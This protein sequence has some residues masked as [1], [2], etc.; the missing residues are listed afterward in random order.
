MVQHSPGKRNILVASSLRGTIFSKAGVWGVTSSIIAVSLH[1]ILDLEKDTE[2]GATGKMLGAGTVGASILGGFT[3]ILGFLIAFRSQQAYSRWWEGGAL[4]QQLRA[5]WFN[6]ASCLLAFS[7]PS[8]EK[9]EEVKQ[10]QNQLVRLI[11]LLHSFALMAVSTMKSKRF[12]L[13]D[14]RGFDKEAL[15]FLHSDACHDKCEVVLQWI[16]RAIVIAENRKVIK[17][18][19]PILSRVYSQLGNGIVNLSNA[20]KITE[21]QIPSPLAQM[22]TVM[23]L[24]HWVA[25]PLICATTVETPYWAGFLCFIVVFSY[26]T[27][28]YIATEL[29]M[30]FGNDLHDLPLGEMQADLNASLLTLLQETTLKCPGY[31]HDSGNRNNYTVAVDLGFDLSAQLTNDSDPWKSYRPE[32]RTPSETSTMPPEAQSQKCSSSF[33]C[34]SRTS[35][36]LELQFPGHEVQQAGECA[37][38]QVLAVLGALLPNVA[39][40]AAGSARR[41]SG[42]K[43]ATGRCSKT[44]PKVHFDG[45]A[46]PPTL[47]R[48]NTG[49]SV[50]GGD[51]DAASATAPPPGCPGWPSQT[52][53]L[54]GPC[55]AF[56][57]FEG[58]VLGE[59]VRNDI[60]GPGTRMMHS[61]Y[62]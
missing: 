45:T 6:A 44:A 58:Q 56:K 31:F 51:D 12:D 19:A 43:D 41:F 22:I 34:G 48:E 60:T 54:T 37:N 18:S 55:A 35:D 46:T 33:S 52:P 49:G 14:L 36:G 38:G 20:R 4:M 11:S 3:F 57:H 28:N 39:A 16:Q 25:T 8:P 42:A 29:E 32:S 7:N 24:F 9:E 61:A 17:I 26:W 30:P 47:S 23:L 59:H 2:D 10:F 53:R 5:E 62:V 50:I 40:K 1:Y 21:F 13:I 15:M 27:I